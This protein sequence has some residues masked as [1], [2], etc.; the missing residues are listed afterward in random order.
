MYSYFMMEKNA[1]NDLTKFIR[2]TYLS[3]GCPKFQHL[4]PYEY[5]SFLI[6]VFFSHPDISLSKI[7]NSYCKQIEVGW[8]DYKP[9]FSNASSNV[10]EQF[11]NSSTRSFFYLVYFFHR[12]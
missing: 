5:H 12:V 2:S 8:R 11:Y 3:G 10:S 6:F 7:Q 9:C 4:H 1:R